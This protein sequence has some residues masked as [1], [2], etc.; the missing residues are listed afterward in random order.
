[1]ADYQEDYFVYSTGVGGER[2]FPPLHGGESADALIS[3]EADSYFKWIKGNYFAYFATAT[4]DPSA[5]AP[6][7]TNGEQIIP[8]IVIDIIDDGS[9]RILMNTPVFVENQFG[10]TG[11]L[12]Y[13]QPTP[14]IFRARSTIRL[15][16]TNIRPPDAG[17]PLQLVCN[18]IGVKGYK[19]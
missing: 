8:P 11:G 13:I 16:A 9:G 19:V 2:S 3:I 6:I 14:R 1:V 7:I 12:P 18:F 4:N 10:M 5:V 17:N 15:R